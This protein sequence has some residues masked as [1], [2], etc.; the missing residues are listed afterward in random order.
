MALTRETPSRKRRRTESAL[1]RTPLVGRVE[2]LHALSRRAPVAAIVI[3]E[4]GAGKSR[5]LAESRDRNHGTPAFTVA[6]QRGAA[7]LPLDPL[8]SLVRAVHRDGLLT[9]AARDAVIGAAERDRLWFIREALETAAQGPVIFQLDDLHWADDATPDALRYCIDRLQDMPIKWHLTSRQGYA[10]VDTFAFA[11]ERAGLADVS[12]IDGLTLGELGDFAAAL[13]GG[14]A[15]DQDVLSRLYERTAGN[16]LYAELLLTN[17]STENAD[18]PRTL[19]WALHDRLTSLSVEAADVA[20]WISVHRGPLA[21]GAIAALSRHS[22]AQVLTAL[23]ELLDKGIARK[24]HEGYAF[25][26]ELLRDVCYEMLD[27]EIRANRHEALA[28]RTTDEWQRAGHFDGARRYEEAAAVLI[29]IG[30]DRLDRDAPTEALAAFERGLDRLS[31]D[32]NSAWEARAG[33]A[34]ALYATGKVETAQSRMRDFEERAPEF[35][36]RLRVLARGRYAEAVWNNAQDVGVV[37]PSLE[38]AIAE[39]RTD[40]PE[41]LA[42]LLGI[43]GGACERQSRLDEARDAF[44]EAITHVDPRLHQREAVRLRAWLG[45]I[46][47]RLGNAREG[48]ALLE[49]AAARAE[50]L[51]MTNELINC[52][53]MLCYVCDMAADPERYEYWCRRGLDIAGPKSRRAQALLMNN[54]AYVSVDKGRLQEA[55]GLSLAAAAAADP[56]S[57]IAVL[58]YFFQAN[59]YSMLG[60]FESAERALHEARTRQ[61]PVPW[62]RAVDFVAGYV[63]ELKCSYDEALKCYEKAAG[64]D[65]RI[66]EVYQIRALAGIVKVS[67][68]LGDRARAQKALERLR[69]VNRHGWPVTRQLVREAEGYWKLLCGDKTGACDDLLAA[70]AENPDRFWQ[71]HLR[72]IVADMQGDRELFMETIDAFDALGAVNAGDHARSLARAHGLRPGRKREAHGILSD[73][74]ISVALYVAN[75]KTNAEIGELLHVSPRTVEF[76][77]GNILSKCGLRSRVEIAIRVAA[78]TL[79][80]AGDQI[81]N[82]TA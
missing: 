41:H 29:R 1:S 69:A 82:T 13:Q 6:C 23:T 53:T 42:R 17:A 28:E 66:D 78:G 24:S 60:D 74:E 31:P 11:L 47:G 37:M 49:E 81:S 32:G 43:F 62:R 50:Q 27:D 12:T 21:Q 5:L 3:G 57:N 59:L 20:A 39:A 18:I 44:E 77:L 58:A 35:D 25:R 54:L 40:A 61:V 76:H 10:S 67:Q 56:S 68:A 2:L 55:L 26:H 38:A 48:I 79:L 8:V 16:P 4:M 34:A 22:P 70:A 9:S 73:R 7:L 80:N 30:W 64:A 75:G 51:G 65:D 19:R 36:A 33:I 15:P 46:R 63:A 72:L 14:P 45:V 52:C 71:A